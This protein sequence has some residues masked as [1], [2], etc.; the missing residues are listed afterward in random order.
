TTTCV[1]LAGALLRRGQ[2]VLVVD[3]DPHASLT[4]YLGFDGDRIEPSAWTLFEAV[5]RD[6][7]PDVAPA[8]HVTAVDGLSLVPASTALVTLER[9]YG[10]RQGMGRV[11]ER[12]LSR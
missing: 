7:A 2:R 10:Q 4:A 6:A 12:S 8:I 9:R 11:L 1:S 3:L 5:A